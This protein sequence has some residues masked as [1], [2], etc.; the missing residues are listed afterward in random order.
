MVALGRLQRPLASAGN[1]ERDD[2]VPPCM[3]ARADVRF[4]TA[5]SGSAFKLRVALG[6]S[7]SAMPEDLADAVEAVAARHG[8]RGEEIPRRRFD[9]LPRG[10]HICSPM[11]AHIRANGIGKRMGKT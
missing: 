11:F 8:D 2:I 1:G 3:M 7:G 9:G 6:G 5:R 10:K 4:A